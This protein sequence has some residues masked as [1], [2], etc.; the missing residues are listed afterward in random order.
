MYSAGLVTFLEKSR[1]RELETLVFLHKLDNEQ[2]CMKTLID[3][4]VSMKIAAK[5]VLSN[6]IS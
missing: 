3:N 6:G 4:K 2:V 5:D 1:F